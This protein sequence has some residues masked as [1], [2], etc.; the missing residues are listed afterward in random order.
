M[1]HDTSASPRTS[2]RRKMLQLSVP[3]RLDEAVKLAASR[4]MCT[5]SDYVRRVLIERLRA[6]GIDPTSAAHV[7][8]SS[9]LEMRA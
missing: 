8:P 6:D 5:I 4:N 2:R 9:S 1:T 7:R 3:R